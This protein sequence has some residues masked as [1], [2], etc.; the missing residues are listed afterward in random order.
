MNVIVVFP[1]AR[2][3]WARLVKSHSFQP[4]GEESVRVDRVIS[5]VEQ[6]GAFAQTTVDSVKPLHG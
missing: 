4:T 6:V 2:L 5:A 3:D 1:L